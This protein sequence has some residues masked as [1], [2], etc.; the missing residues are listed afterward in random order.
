MAKERPGYHQWTNCRL[1]ITWPSSYR[2]IWNLSKRGR[3]LSIFWKKIYEKFQLRQKIRIKEPLNFHRLTL[4]LSAP[5]TELKSPSDHIRESKLDTR[6]K[7]IARHRLRP[8][9]NPWIK[10]TMY[11]DEQNTCG[12][13]PRSDE[14]VKV[15]LHCLWSYNTS[16][17]IKWPSFQIL[18]RRRHSSGSTTTVG[19]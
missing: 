14:R 15:Q 12:K 19:Y 6:N 16:H 1:L 18:V 9:R 2:Q 3:G 11:M 13:R 17:T 7:S 5:K 10:P 4:S 8:E